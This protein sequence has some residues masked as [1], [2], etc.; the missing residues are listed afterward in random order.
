MMSLIFGLFTKVSDLGPHGP[1]VFYASHFSSPEPKA[2]GE[3]IV[4]TCSVVRRRQSVVR[5]QFQKISP[6]KPLDRW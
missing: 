4:R 2:T 1:L 5:P 6:L 3:L